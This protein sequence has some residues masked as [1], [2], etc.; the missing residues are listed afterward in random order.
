MTRVLVTGAAG[1][2]GRAVSALLHEEGVDFVGTD[3][4]DPGEV[5][6]P[7][8][9]AD[10]LDHSGVS[11]LLEGVDVVMHL[12]NHAG[13]GPVPPQI[14]FGRNTTMNTNVFQGAAE[15]GLSR[16]IFASTLQLIGSHV[17]SRTVSD[18]PTPPR[19]PLSGAT[20]AQPSNLYALS[21]AVAEQMLQYYADRCGVDC[22]ALRLPLLH[23]GENSRGVNTGS[24]T[25]IDILEGFTGLTYRDAAG[26]FL[27]I[28]RSDLT[29]YRSYMVGTAHR[30]N[31]FDVDDLIRTFYPAVPPGTPDLIDCS[32]L[33]RETGWVA[34]DDYHHS[35]SQDPT[36]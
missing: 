35:P 18:P 25:I 3:I 28:L 31:D 13:L 20:L 1:R 9:P 12:G 5:P 16:I 36:P 22:V 30:H 2:L 21:K 33:T 29:G 14:V 19:F 24:E 4:V 17:D 8:S 11:R 27:A 23:H 15:H 32:A 10:L 26:A 34:V 6:Y 7:F